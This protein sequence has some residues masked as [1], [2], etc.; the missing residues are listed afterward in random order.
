MKYGV[1][2]NIRR[3]KKVKPAVK[4]AIIS[5]VAIALAV[6]VFLLVQRKNS[7][8]VSELTTY[9]MGAY[10][11]QSVYGENGQEA[12]KKASSAINAMEPRLSKNISGSD[13][14]N[15]NAYAGNDPVKVSKITMSILMKAVEIA[16]LSDG[17]FEPTI[18]PYSSAWDFDSSSNIIPE[19]SQLKGFQSLVGYA[20]L[21]LDSDKRTARLDK[22][23]EGVDLGAIGKGAACDTAIQTYKEN[24]V[25]SA[26]VSVGGSVGVLGRKVNGKDWDIGIR[27]PQKSMQGD[28]NATMG[29][30]SLHD[31][32]VSTSGVYE[33]YFIKDNKV[34]HHILDPKT[35]YPVDNNLM[36]V[37]V[38]CDNGAVSDALTTACFVLGKDNSSNLL[39]HYNALAIF[40]DKENNVS[41][42]GDIGNMF[43]I[44]DD[45]YKLCS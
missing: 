26:V 37:T 40:I 16:K 30:L 12:T 18:L 31:S 33:K 21:T 25:E 4:Y 14:H 32:F 2:H 29:T 22:Q 42:V 17:A 3:E 35:G 20:H 36:S 23:R 9:A 44:T 34:Y 5:V 7:V 28:K 27:D 15:I 8:Q 19:D 38:V 39:N 10:V 45:N 1:E 6:A 13:I 11:T 24:G 43:T 41:T